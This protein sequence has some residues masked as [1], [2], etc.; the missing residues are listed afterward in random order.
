MAA[1]DQGHPRRQ[2]RQLKQQQV[3]QRQELARTPTDRSGLRPRPSKAEV[4]S[5]LE[6]GLPRN[7]GQHRHGL[8][9]WQRLF[10]QPSQKPAPPARKQR[11]SKVGSGN[12]TNLSLR[13]TTSKDGLTKFR[14]KPTSLVQATPAAREISSSKIQNDRLILDL[15]LPILDE[16]EY[17]VQGLD[18][19]NY[20]TNPK[21]KILSS[22]APDFSRGVNPKSK[23]L[24]CEGGHRDG[25]RQDAHF[26]QNPKSN[27][28]SSR[29]VAGASRQQRSK[30]GAEKI[31]KSPQPV[32]PPVSV[33]RRS[34]PKQRRNSSGVLVYG[35]RLL[36]L[37]IGLGA[38]VGTI[39]SIL[40]PTIHKPS[41]I[42]ETVNPSQHSAVA[43]VSLKPA[44]TFVDGLTA[45]KLTQEIMPLRTAV[46]SLANQ[47][48]RLAPG[49]FVLDIDTGAYLDWNGAAN[50]AAASTIKIPILVAFFQ[51]VDAGKI[52]LD[53]VLA[54]EQEA[55]ASGSGKMQYKPPGTKY[56]ALETVTQMITISDNT[57]TNMLIARLG[58]AEALNQ[59][60]LDW[61]LT[62]TAIRNKLPDIEGTNTT[63]SKELASL[64]VRVNQG[65]LVSLPSRDRLLSIMRRTANN[66]LLPRGLGK[67]A[68]IAHKTGNIGSMLADVGLI[69]LPSG[70]RYIAAVMVKRPRNDTRAAELINKISRVTYQYFSKPIANPQLP[71]GDGTTP[72]NSIPSPTPINRL[73]DTQ[74]VNAQRNRG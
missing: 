28:P 62:A 69:D 49:I 6:R 9:W 53:E 64:M 5:A 66:S 46:Q 52:R 58:G 63:S 11:G 29:P 41:A 71:A 2:R 74:S 18:G 39:L 13:Q 42:S 40:N 7:V 8:N 37:G 59:R 56:T 50:L 24:S 70:K 51:D 72:G 3:P 16:E 32:R 35:M 34:L 25:N 45:L 68:N 14:A 27:N 33:Q 60:F 19:F 67:G 31:R 15:G 20:R 1:S 10:G 30:V 47:Y 65:E 55:I 61:G 23:I 73:E 48:P 17:S 38:I 36:I 44:S 21:S 26:A 4:S 57:A 12:L 54:L 22:Q 43:D